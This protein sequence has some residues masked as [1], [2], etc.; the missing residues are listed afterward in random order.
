VPGRLDGKVAIVTGAGSGI[1]RAAARLF[2]DEGARV[3]CADRSGE[4]ATTAEGIGDAAIAVR[5]DVSVAADVERMVAT[6]ESAFGQLDV[7]FNNAGFGGPIAPLAEQ[8]ED[9]WDEVHAVNLKG[10]F[11]RHEVR[12]PRPAAPTGRVGHQH[13]V[14]RR[15][16]RHEGPRRLQRGEGGRD[17]AHQGGRPRL[18]R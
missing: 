11:L 15:H 14:R 13:G 3:V 10:V 9:V 4:E 16:R 6:A 12:H 7:L 1:G 17:P 18:R 2:A 8:P 5:V